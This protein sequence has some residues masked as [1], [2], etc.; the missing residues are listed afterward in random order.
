MD[1]MAKS[2]NDL[3][4]NIL[5]PTDSIKKLK[6]NKSSKSS[7]SMKEEVKKAKDDERKMSPLIKI[8][9]NADS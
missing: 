7:K 5:R 8:L 6:K 2:P 4:G 3:S 9:Q 1:E